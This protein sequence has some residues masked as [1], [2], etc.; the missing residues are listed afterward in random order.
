M[1]APALRDLAHDQ[2]VVLVREVFLAGHLIDRAGMPSLLGHVSTDVMAEVA[3]EEWRGAS[4]VYTRRMQRLLGF[5][6]DDVATVFKGMQLDIGAPPQFLDFRYTVHDRDHGEFRLAH[7]G[8]LMDVE[9]MGE[10]LVHAMCHTIEDPTFPATACATNPRAVTSP[11][12]RPPRT[13]E[14]LALGPEHP[15]CH[16]RLDIDEANEPAPE[17]TEAVRLAATLAAAVPLPVIDDPGAGRVDYSGP[18]EDDVDFAAFSPGALAA[19]VDEAS[20][21]GH[22]LVLSFLASAAERLGPEVAMELGRAQL[23]GVGGVAADRLARALALGGGLG[24]VA[25][26]LAVHPAFLPRTYVDLRV[27]EAEGSLRVAL[28][29]CPALHE[30]VAPSWMTVL[31]ASDPAVPG[32]LDAIVQG[33]E[34]RARCRPTDP[35]DAVAA[36]EVVLVD[37]PAPEPD[38][39]VLTRFSTGASFTFEDR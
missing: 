3:I 21:Q 13:P 26:V 18:L 25:A 31:E 7:C 9:P 35:G 2:L 17:P 22:L 32:P 30:T 8:A 15:H 10:E 16:W 6:G 36:W 20:L 5:Q 38:A 29:D 28:H 39:V 19:M 11:I 14:A 37:E 34:P 4:P 33:A 24:A 12:H 1:T 27:E 23:T